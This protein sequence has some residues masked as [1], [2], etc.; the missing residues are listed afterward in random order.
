MEIVYDS[1]KSASNRRKHGIGFAEAQTALLDEHALVSEDHDSDG[2]QRFVLLGRSIQHHLL[3][4]VYA[5]WDEQAEVIRLIS[6]RRATAHEEK[7]YGY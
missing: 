2:E 5:I 1:R 4:V 7:S 3:V 6:A